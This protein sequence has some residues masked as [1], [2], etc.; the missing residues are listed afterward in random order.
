MPLPIS[1]NL[2][3]IG[4]LVAGEELHNNHHAFPSSAKFSWRPWE[5]DM[6]WLHLKVFS[7]L[8][9]AKIKRVAPVPEMNLEPST[10][11][12]DA[13]RAIIVNRMH[14]LRHYTHSVILPALRRD[15]GSP[16]QKNSVVIRQTKKL[17]TWHPSM[18][19]ELS[20]QRLLEIV[21]GYPSVQTVVAF[22]DELKD[23]WEGSHSSNENLLADFRSW[24]TKAEASGIKG[25]QEFS[26]YLQSFR[27]IPATA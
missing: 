22:R 1:T 6:G 13:L 23:L 17:L 11:D 25:L 16:D 19:D 18:L 2:W 15:L 27:S 20:K 4:I 5:V 3:P 21:E 7:A 26:S 24:C 9:L 14:V 12:I 8:G 10:P